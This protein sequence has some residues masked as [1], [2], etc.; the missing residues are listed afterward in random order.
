MQKILSPE[1]VRNELINCF[2]KAHCEDA[3]S[4]LGIADSNITKQYCED[5]VRKAFEE[6]QSDFENP[7][8]EG[9]EKVVGYLAKFS[10]GFRD[11]KIIEK[12]VNKIMGMIDK[13][14]E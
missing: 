8:K 2:F 12:H 4:G 7:T 1:E 5:I 10:A 14:R 11:K 13:I 3:S 9:L 6:T